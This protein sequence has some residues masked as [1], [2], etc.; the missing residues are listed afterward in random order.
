MT[1]AHFAAMNPVNDGS[2]VVFT[3]VTPG[4]VQTR[5]LDQAA[6]EFKSQAF[7]VPQ[8][9]EAVLRPVLGNVGLVTGA[10]VNR[11]GTVGEKSAIACDPD[12][13]ARLVQHS[14]DVINGVLS[15]PAS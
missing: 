6:P 5:L 9:A 13:C 4:P 7:T 10:F 3:S 2:R 8:G 12:A 15:R 14:F 1:A 11:D